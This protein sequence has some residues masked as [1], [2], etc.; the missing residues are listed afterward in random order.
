MLYETIEINNKE[1]KLCLPMRHTIQLEKKIGT[2]PLNKLME[3]SNSDGDN[4]LPDFEFI[5]YVFHYSLQKY[6]SNISL[7]DTFDLVDKYL[8]ENDMAQLIQ[9]VMK[10]FEVSGFFKIP[11]TATEEAETKEIKKK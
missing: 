10:I 9:T 3:M 1:Y 7:E 8:E 2:N 11:E 5:T 6:Q 4:K